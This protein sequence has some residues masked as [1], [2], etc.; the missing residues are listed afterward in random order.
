MIQQDAKNINS[1]KLNTSAVKKVYLNQKQVFPESN[2][3][4]YLKLI[5]NVDFYIPQSCYPITLI[6]SPDHY[7]T[8]DQY[9]DGGKFEK[10]I[11]IGYI[12][13]SQEKI[14][15]DSGW[16]NNVDIITSDPNR[17]IS[18]DSRNA[19]K[20]IQSYTQYEIYLN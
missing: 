10:Y 12:T 6:F 2:T 4:Y 7:I 15:T 16:L 8:I 20:D 11:L 9:P 17:T 3:P 18:Y 5:A 1:I 14:V 13:E 19:W